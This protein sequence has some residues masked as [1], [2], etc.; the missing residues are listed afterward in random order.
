MHARQPPSEASGIEVTGFEPIGPRPVERARVQSAPADQ[1]RFGG[2]SGGS[3]PRPS[4]SRTMAPRSD[5]T[6]VVSNDQSTSG[7]TSPTGAL[8]E[9]DPASSEL[10][11]C[12]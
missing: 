12:G 5:R 2:G 6:G 3:A 7:S 9:V 10:R 4:G 8:G 11:S 1:A